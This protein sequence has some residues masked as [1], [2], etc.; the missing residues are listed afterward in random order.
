M[1]EAIDRFLVTEYKSNDSKVR[2]TFG[3]KIFLNPQDEGVSPRISY[4]GWYEGGTTRLFERLLKPGMR[5]VD[6]GANIGWFSLLAAKLV[7]NSGAVYAFEPEVTCARFLRKSAQENGFANLQIEQLCVSNSVG[8]ITLYVA[9]ASHGGN[10]TIRRSESQ[11]YQF[12]RPQDCTSLDAYFEKSQKSISLLKIDVEG[13]EPEVLEGA[14]RLVVS[15]LVERIIMEWN[16]DSW[17]EKRDLLNSLF[18]KYRVYV[19]A[20]TVPF[21]LLRPISNKQIEWRAGG[22]LYFE[23][24]GTKYMKPAESLR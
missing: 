11:S 4:H 13:A 15:E 1:Y 22:V 3:F 7:G 16:P 18:Q 21:P 6:V 20:N 17:I 10:S 8:S 19:V 14:Q 24:I 12:S 9:V 23:A 5:F 2:E